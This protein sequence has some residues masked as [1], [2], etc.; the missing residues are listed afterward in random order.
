MRL[1]Q[2]RMTDLSSKNIW[3]VPLSERPF[4]YVGVEDVGDY[5]IETFVRVDVCPP[6]R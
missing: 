2:G 3:G 1:G 5:A 4:S 6:E